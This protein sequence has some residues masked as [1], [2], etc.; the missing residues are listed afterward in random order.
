MKTNHLVIMAGGVGSRFWPLS[1]PVRPKQFVDILGTGKTLL[2]M[3]AERFATVC[4]PENI[5]VVTSKNYFRLV[6]EQLPLIKEEHILL[7]PCMR[8]TAPCIAYVTWK[9]KKRYP[10]ANIVVSP[11]DH[12]VLDTQ[13][14]TRLIKKGLDFTASHDSI[15]TLGITP[16]RPETGYGYIQMSGEKHDDDEIVKVASF[17]EKPNLETAKSYLSEGIYLWNSGIFLWNV[18]TIEA[19]FRKYETELAAIFDTLQADFYTE[20]EQ[21]LIDNHFP[22]CKNISIDY[23]VMERSDNIYVLPADCGWSDV[24]TWGSLHEISDR[25]EEN[26]TVVGNGVRLVECSDCIA[27]VSDHVGV[28]AQGLEG[29]IIAENNGIVLICKKSEEQRIREFSQMLQR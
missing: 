28:V 29:Y 7:E 2:Q 16:N 12:L 27:H 18:A 4:P 24:G 10:D 14:F 15:L 25:D 1:T 11:S 22:T 26:N 9:I 19:A 17:K 8:N 5:W 6:K 23:A 13:E 21:I 3:T 20:K